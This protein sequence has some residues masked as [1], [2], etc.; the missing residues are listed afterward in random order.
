M[1]LN[2]ASVMTAQPLNIQSPLDTYNKMLS[3]QHLQAQIA[4]EQRQQQQLTAQEEHF[5]QINDLIK[6]Q[7][8]DP[9]EIGRAHV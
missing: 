7:G 1:P 3:A 4:A 6:Q 8:L 2:P 5:Q 9:D